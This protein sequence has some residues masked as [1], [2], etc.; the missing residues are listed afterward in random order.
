MMTMWQQVEYRGWPNCYRLANGEVALLVTTD[1]GPRIL[2]FGFVGEAN[3]LGEFAETWGKMGEDEWR[4]YGG[5]RLWHAPEVLPRTYYP[6]NGPVE[7]EQQGDFIRLRPALETT[8]GIQKEIDIALHPERAEVRLT[9]RLYNRNAWPITFAPWALTVMATG[10]TAIVPLPPRG[11][12]PEQ[13]LPTSSLTLWAYTDMSDP[14]WTWGERYVLLRQEPRMGRPQKIGAFV[15]DGWVAYARNGHLFVKTF[16]VTAG[17]VY[18]DRG[19]NV[20]LFTNEAMIE[21]E[22]LGPLTLVEPGA[23]VEHVER[24][25][26]WRD[27]A[28]PAG[29]GDVEKYMAPLI[30]KDST[31]EEKSVSSLSL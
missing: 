11:T 4:S 24:W 14:R 22:T 31:D 19:C 7:W 16:E 2:Q 5:H 29:E 15:P 1:V 6:D 10:G 13:L 28:R 25:Y 20:E 8:T 9:H 18:P 27:V 26:L 30:Q 12:H 17:G 23:A 21:L 3:E